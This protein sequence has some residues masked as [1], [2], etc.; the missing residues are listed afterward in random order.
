MNGLVREQIDGGC[1][2]LIENAKQWQLAGHDIHVM[3]SAQAGISCQQ[4]GLRPTLHTSRWRG[5]DSRW[6]L[7]LHSITVCLFLPLSL[8]RLHPDLIV[9]SHDQPY[10]V[11]PGVMLKLQRWRRVRLAVSVPMMMRWRFWRRK[12]PRWYNALAFLVAQRLSLLLAAFFANCTLAHSRATAR[13]LRRTGFP[14]RRVAAVACGVDLAAIGAVTPRPDVPQ[15]D[16]VSVGRLAA[17]KGALDLVDAWQ[18]VVARKPDAKLAIIGDGPD[19]DAM[20]DRLRLHGLES[21]VDF[22]GPILDPAKKFGRIGASRLFTLPSH[23]ESW[24]IAMGEA[25]ALGVPVVAYDLPEL[26]EVWGDAFHAVPEGDIPAFANAVSCLLADEAVCHEIAERGLARVSEL[27][28]SVIA[29]R[30]LRL[31][32][33]DLADEDSLGVD[34]SLVAESASR[35]SSDRPQPRPP[36]STAD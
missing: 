17:S 11:L 25:M 15:Y 9:T 30:E 24:S 16:A 5:G 28:W 35:A 23:E 18:I 20:K 14:M 8:W 31:L 34:P 4:W 21:S 2:R 19:G 36:N 12:G 33:G 7:A 3:G 22:L 1:V 13:Q 32:M 26:L 29:E 10:D 27:D 6:W